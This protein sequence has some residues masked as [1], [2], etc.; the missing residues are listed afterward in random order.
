MCFSAEA[1]FGLSTALAASGAYCV[2][3]AVR[4]QNRS[5]LP[6]AAIPL[7]FGI[8]QFC[9][10]LVWVGL[11]ER[12]Q[13]LVERASLAYLFFALFFWPL[14]MPLSIFA[15]ERRPTQNFIMAVITVLGVACGLALYLPL[16]LNLALVV[17]RIDHHS[18][19]YDFEQSPVFDI[20]PWPF[21]IVLYLAVVA[22]PILMSRRRE[23]VVVGLVLVMLAG[24][25]YVISATAFVSLW[26]FFAAILSIYLCYSFYQMPMPAGHGAALH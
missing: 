13:D 20:V 6:L 19:H 3:T 5:H 14:W 8:Q 2:I 11:G 21:W 22:A 10:G 1:S 23:V 24:I 17:T 18:I 9:E 12:H 25:T 15:Q 26:C 7:F 4:R 16:V